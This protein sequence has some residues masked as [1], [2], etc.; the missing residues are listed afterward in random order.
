MISVVMTLYST[1]C[2]QDHS[3]SSAFKLL[4]CMAHIVVSLYGKACASLITLLAD[5]QIGPFFKT[6][7]DMFLDES[8]IV[9]YFATQHAHYLSTLIANVFV[10]SPGFS[11]QG[12]VLGMA[13]HKLGKVSGFRSAIYV[14]TL[15]EHKCLQKNKFFESI[16]LVCPLNIQVDG[17]GSSCWE[18]SLKKIV[19]LRP[20][21]HCVPAAVNHL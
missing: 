14:K 12:V 1:I 3:T 17:S 8:Y 4:L 5:Y 2:V 9:A 11:T 19:Q 20:R 21:Q 6:L 7:L 16:R 13:S 18:F 10:S 15:P